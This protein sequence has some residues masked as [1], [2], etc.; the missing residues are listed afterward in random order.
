M[1]REILSP[2]TWAELGALAAF[3]TVV[4]IAFG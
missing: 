1:I 3:I 2:K 4:L